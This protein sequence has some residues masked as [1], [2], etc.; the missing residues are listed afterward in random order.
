M[1]ENKEVENKTLNMFVEAY[2]N[3]CKEFGMAIQTTPEFKLRDD[4]TFSV[5]LVNKIVKLENQND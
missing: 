3:L 5:I 1:K 4:G 2:N